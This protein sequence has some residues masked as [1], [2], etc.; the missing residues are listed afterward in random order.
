M[1]RGLADTSVFVALEGSR[2]LGPLPEDMAASVITAAELELGVLSAA[3][4]STRSLR[5]AT[6]ER[7]RREVALVPITRATASLFAALAAEMREAGR[8]P[9]IHD[10]WI[11]ATAVLLGV[12]VYTQDDDF[13]AIPRVEVV[14]V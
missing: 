2:T 10:T 5:I 12:P 14:K 9:K 11:A 1:S 4:V 8:R 13:D 6:L 7:V 3:D